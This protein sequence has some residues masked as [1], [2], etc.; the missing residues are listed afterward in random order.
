MDQVHLHMLC[1]PI[2]NISFVQT[3]LWSK[4]VLGDV[5][6]NAFMGSRCL[7]VFDSMK[8]CLLSCTHA[9]R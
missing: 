4:C 1:G 9:G 6:P 3:E 8:E 2:S 5:T 7:Q